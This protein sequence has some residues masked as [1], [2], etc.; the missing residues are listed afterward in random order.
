MGSELTEMT[1]GAI[2]LVV[3]HLSLKG[4]ADVRGGAAKSDE[5][6]VGATQLTCRPWDW[7]QPVMVAMSWSERPK[8]W[9]TSSGVSQ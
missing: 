2:H 3:V 4:A 1:L 6:A 5:D 7:S 8:R 9:P